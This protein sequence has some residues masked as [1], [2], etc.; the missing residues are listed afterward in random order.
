MVPSMEYRVRG[1]MR[2]WLVKLYKFSVLF[3]LL[4]EDGGMEVSIYEIYESK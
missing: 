3:V 2:R 4:A 1:S